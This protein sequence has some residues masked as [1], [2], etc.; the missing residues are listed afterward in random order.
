MKAKKNPREQFHIYALAAYLE[1]R[2]ELQVNHFSLSW[3][4]IAEYAIEY[5]RNE[6]LLK[7]D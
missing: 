4:E 6:G 5:L 1:K 7:E 2:E 3:E